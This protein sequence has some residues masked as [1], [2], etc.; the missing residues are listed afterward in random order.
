MNMPT[1][2]GKTLCSMKFALERAVKTG[3]KRIIY[4][5]PY[6]SIIDQTVDEFEKTFGESAQILRHQSSFS[7]DDTDKDEDYRQLLKNVTENWNAQII[8]TTSVQF[9]ESVYANKRN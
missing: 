1:S 4:V 2:S 5:I 8:V 9:F 3:K 7:I 6:N